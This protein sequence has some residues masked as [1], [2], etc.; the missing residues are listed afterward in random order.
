VVDAA[1]LGRIAAEK[2]VASRNPVAIE[3]GLYTAVLE[4]AAVAGIMRSLLGAFNARANDEGRGTLSKPGGGTKLGEKIVDS[5]VTID[6]DPADPDLLASPFAADGTPVRR[7]T[8]IENGVLK[9]FADDRYWAKRQGK[10]T[11]DLIAGTERGILVTQFFYTNALDARTVLLSGLT[12]DGTFL[13]ENGKITLA[14]KN[15]RWIESPLIMLNKLQAL[16]RAEPVGAG[17]LMPSLRALGF[18]FASLS[19]AV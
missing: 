10:T 17:R 15:F 13:I 5:R 9:E 16:G 8:Y 12:R 6:S 1:A 4:P 18:N 2:A 14:L 19:D 11:A 7:V 3:P